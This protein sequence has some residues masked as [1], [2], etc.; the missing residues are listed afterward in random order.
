[1]DIDV[2]E[3]LRIGR[4][5]LPSLAGVKFSDPP[6]HDLRR[7]KMVSRS[8]GDAF[9]VFFG[10]DDML[11]DGLA[12]GADGAV[13]STYNF[14]APLYRQLINAFEDGDRK[15]AKRLQEQAITMLDAI[16]QCC[17]RAGLKAAMRLVGVDCGPHRLPLKSAGDPGVEK[18]DEAF[19]RIGFSEWRRAAQPA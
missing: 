10:V 6:L 14:A 5:R 2:S 13:G 8:D 18:L 11:L 19:G 17:G 7:C 9:E 4:G 3:L 15:E 1:M 16:F 12:A